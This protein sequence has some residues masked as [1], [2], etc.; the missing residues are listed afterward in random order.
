M[1]SSLKL[2]LESDLTILEEIVKCRQ[3]LK[4]GNIC[5]SHAETVKTILINNAKNEIDKLTLENKF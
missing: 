4:S 1:T 5:K 3:C 2:L